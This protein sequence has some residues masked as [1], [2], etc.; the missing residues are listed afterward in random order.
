MRM[1]W[2][3]DNVEGSIPAFDDLLPQSRALV[4]LIGLYRDAIPP[5]TGAPA[6]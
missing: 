6:L 2:L 3:C 1:D 4:R 5:E